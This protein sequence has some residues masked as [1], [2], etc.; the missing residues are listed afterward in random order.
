[1]NKNEY[2]EDEIKILDVDVEHLK[3]K[4]EELGAKKVYQDYREVI[5]LDTSDRELLTK[6]DKLIRITDEGSVKVTMHVNQSKQDEK[7]EIKFKV[8]RMKEVIDFFAELDIKP[9][10][11]VKEKRTSYELGKV[12][13]DIDEFPKIPPFLEIDKEFLESEG[14]TLDELLE[15]LDLTNNKVVVMGTE[16]IHSLYGIDYFEV[17][18][19]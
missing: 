2:K 11:E 15:K 10:T 5:S 18:K 6:K 14:Y 4:L 3:L 13:F 8:S 1:M 16:D 19:V 12:D 9:V 17:Y 7:Q